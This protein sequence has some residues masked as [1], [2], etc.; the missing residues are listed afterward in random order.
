MRLNFYISPYE[1][2]KF[3][4]GCEVAIYNV[5]TAT[6]A[7]TQDA[8]DEILEMSL[9][10]VPEDTGTL[11]DTAFAEVQRN[12]AT[13]RYT[14]YGIVGYAGMAGAGASHDKVNPVTGQP[15]SSYAVV[16]HED[17]NADHDTK[18]TGKKAKFLEDPVR[19]YE[20]S[21]KFKRVAK[22]HWDYAIRQSEKGGRMYVQVPARKK[23]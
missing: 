16:V 18:Y 7:A 6:K 4:S 14:Y 1:V 15:A 22:T 5:G 3:A 19:D 21:G 2:N 8:C 12:E 23:E 11:A 13:K 20:W 10:E 9:M 17:L